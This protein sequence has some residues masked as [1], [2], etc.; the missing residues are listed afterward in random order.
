VD[1][2]G[3]QAWWKGTQA[4]VRAPPLNSPF[5]HKLLQQTRTNA[6]G[7][8]LPQIPTGQRT[9][10]QKI[11]AGLCWKAPAAFPIFKQTKRT[12]FGG[13]ERISPAEPKAEECVSILLGYVQAI[14]APR[15]S[16]QQCLK[17]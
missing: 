13:L 15:G 14:P 16:C 11:L 17:L 3:Q 4:A 9:N 8:D 1:R 12:F 2:R 7:I 5:T 6:P 10:Q